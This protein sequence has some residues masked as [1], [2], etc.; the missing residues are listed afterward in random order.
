MTGCWSQQYLSWKQSTLVSK[1]CGRA[2]GGEVVD[3]VCVPVSVVGIS[4]DFSH[5]EPRFVLVR[6]ELGSGQQ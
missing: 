1:S 5:A 6:Q 3:L 2:E 4:L